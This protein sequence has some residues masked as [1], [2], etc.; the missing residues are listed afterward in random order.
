MYL[1][2]EGSGNLEVFPQYSQNL[3]RHFVN[4]TTKSNSIFKPPKN[5]DLNNRTKIC[6]L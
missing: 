5:T 3:Y 4:E 6:S 1:K 2:K